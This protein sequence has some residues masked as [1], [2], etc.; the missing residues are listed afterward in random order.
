VKSKRDGSVLSKL[1][2]SN[3]LIQNENEEIVNIP[4]K[5]FSSLLSEASETSLIPTDLLRILL[6]EGK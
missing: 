5:M 4:T 2:F 3:A 1:A 6:R